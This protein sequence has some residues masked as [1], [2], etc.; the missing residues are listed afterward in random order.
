M[1]HGETHTQTGGRETSALACAASGPEAL[2]PYDTP[3]GNLNG[4][5]PGPEKG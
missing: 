1:T 2:A 5:R 3:T 4:V